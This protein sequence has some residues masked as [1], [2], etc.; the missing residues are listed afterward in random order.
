MPTRYD[1]GDVDH[2]GRIINDEVNLTTLQNVS[3]MVILP[4][5]H[6][7]DELDGDA[8]NGLSG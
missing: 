1:F 7:G 2:F 3:G 6:G 4:Y 5:N 8:T